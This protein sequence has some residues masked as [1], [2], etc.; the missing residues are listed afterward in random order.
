MT[1]DWRDLPGGL[2]DAETTPRADVYPPPPSP[3]VKWTVAAGAVAAAYMMLRS[4]RRLPRVAPE[5][6]HRPLYDTL[7]VTPKA[8][9]RLEVEVRDSYRQLR[10]WRRVLDV[11]SQYQICR[12]LAGG[13]WELRHGFYPHSDKPLWWP[14]DGGAGRPGGSAGE[15][16]A[17]EDWGEKDSR[18]K[19][20]SAYR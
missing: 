10:G 9:L 19:Q 1:H 20:R 4:G 12:R 16:L 11:F 13:I 6:V 8:V 2:Q 18:P 5:R 3:L 7:R 17:I 14:V 15:A